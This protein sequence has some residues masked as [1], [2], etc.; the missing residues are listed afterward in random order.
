M[1]TFALLLPF[2]SRGQSSSRFIKDTGVR[3][4][5]APRRTHVPVLPSRLLWLHLLRTR[6]GHRANRQFRASQRV[7]WWLSADAFKEEGHRC[8]WNPAGASPSSCDVKQRASGLGKSHE[9]K[10]SLA[11]GTSVARAVD[12]FP[13]VRS[14]AALGATR[15][16]A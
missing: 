10:V 13:V 8:P 2:V 1:W 12:Y 11:L 3:G 14:E 9:P 5:P 7:S 6:P 15:G 16:S 4:G